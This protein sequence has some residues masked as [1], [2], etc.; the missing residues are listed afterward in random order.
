MWLPQPLR[1]SDDSENLERQIIWPIVF[2]LDSW[3]VLFH[4]IRFVGNAPG[5]AEGNRV[6]KARTELI[7]L[8]ASSDTTA[9]YRSSPVWLHYHRVH[10]GP[11]QKIDDSLEQSFDFQDLEQ[12]ILC[13]NPL[14]L[15]CVSTGI[16]VSQK[17]SQSI[18]RA[19]GLIWRTSSQTE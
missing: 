7:A 4:W 2:V 18:T 15:N 12:K 10:Q 11:K 5:V 19:L 1:S 6:E 9:Y 14:R 8:S 13:P 16:A 3:G 17:V